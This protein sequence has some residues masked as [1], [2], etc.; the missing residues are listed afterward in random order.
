GDRTVTLL[1]GPSGCGKTTAIAKLAAFY[2]LEEKRS[3]A[4]ITFDTYRQSSV[5]QLRMYAGVLGVPF[6]SAVSAR[7]V[8][9]GLRRHRQPDVVLIDVPGAGP[10][11]LAA[12]C[13]LQHLLR[14]EGGVS[15][16]LVIPA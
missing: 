6:A 13:E 7:Q 11:E 2:R 3:A 16:Q 9:E 14:D 10:E 5:E 15:V 4:V 12:A 8:V 1:L